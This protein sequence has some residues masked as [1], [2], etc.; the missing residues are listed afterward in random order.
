MYESAITITLSIS[1]AKR[2]L[3]LPAMVPTLKAADE[4]FIKVSKSGITT[5]KLKM[6]IS[7]KLLLV[8]EA[9]A[10]IMVRADANPKLP[11]NNALMNKG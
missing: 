5:G 7:A 4:T 11:S 10:A 6:A 2:Y 8:R 9:M 3:R 1:K